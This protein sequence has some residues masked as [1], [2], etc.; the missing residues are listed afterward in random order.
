MEHFIFIIKGLS[1]LISVDVINSFPKILGDLE[2]IS[3][4]SFILELTNQVIKEN[5]DKEIYELLK[6]SLIKIEEGYNPLVI[7]NILE[8][9][10]LNYLGVSPEVDSCSICGSTKD[11]I[12]ISSLHGGYVCRECYQND[13]IIVS[14][15]TIKMIRL[16]YYV[17][18]NKITKLDVS[19]NLSKEINT[20]LDDYY[21]KYTGLYLKT[22]SFLKN[23][24][25]L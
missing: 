22:K 6:A 17:D 10:Y 11:I 21:D 5:D 25:K 23:L 7:T 3:Y 2:K 1:T 8:L 24:N 12:T 4:A 15:K 9:K 16:F 20:F 19:N 13:D 18:I 14:D